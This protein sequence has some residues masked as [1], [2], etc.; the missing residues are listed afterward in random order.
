MAKKMD[1]DFAGL[2]A[3]VEHS[4]SKGRTREALVADFA[5]LYLPSTVK[6]VQSA[7]IIAADGSVSRECDVAVVDSTTPALL[8]LGGYSVLPIECVHA[9]IEVKSDL[10]S[11][12]LE[13]AFD[14][15][16]R[17]K[18]MPKTA[19]YPQEGDVIRGSTAYG[20]D[21]D[22]FPTHGFVFA[23]DS[24]DLKTLRKRLDEL[25]APLPLWQRVDSIWVLRKGAIMN[26]SDRASVLAPLPGPGFR[27]R[28]FGSTNPLF[29]AA[30]TLQAAMVN[31]WM[32]RFRLLDYLARSVAIADPLEP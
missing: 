25:N 24:I 20:R 29:L 7:E 18:K 10:D 28:A 32:P 12:E 3:Q 1:L 31:A 14:K 23:F 6:V 19:L 16:V 17:I 11:A 4:P 5:R 27:L 13:D 15:I 8:A 9:V 22:Y 21:W 30:T 26:W 2:T